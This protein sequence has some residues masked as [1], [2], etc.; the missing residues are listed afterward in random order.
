ML[1]SISLLPCGTAEAEGCNLPP[2]FSCPFSHPETRLKTSFP[3]AKS[4]ACAGLAIA[5]PREM[6]SI[7]VK[8][9]Y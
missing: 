6:A 3:P 1:L 4:A 5:A 8:R 7:S 9:R 2:H